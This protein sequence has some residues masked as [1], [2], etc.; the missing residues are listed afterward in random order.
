MYAFAMIS[1]GP[2]TSSWR[3]NFVADGV[4]NAL[5]THPTL[6]QR[7]RALYAA[8]ADGSVPLRVPAP[9]GRACWLRWLLGSGRHG[10]GRAFPRAALQ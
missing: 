7:V 6:D 10:E 9:A 8:A 3:R 2:T 4:N 5:R 1:D